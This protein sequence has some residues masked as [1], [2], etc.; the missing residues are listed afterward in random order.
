MI[1]RPPRS[2]LFP[3]TT[4]F[5][6]GIID[7]AIVEANETVVVTLTGFGAHDPDI[8]L[9][10]TPTTQAHTAALHSHFTLA[11]PLLPDNNTAAET[12][13]D[14]GQLTGSLTQQRS[15]DTA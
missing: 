7:D 10:P 13:A 1:R 15:T 11:C 9:D 6:S 4:L 12:G 14:P 5:R 2:T 3:Y 8:T